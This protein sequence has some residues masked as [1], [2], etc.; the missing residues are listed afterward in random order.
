MV[1]F[2]GR[3]DGNY[4]SS[5][6]ADPVNAE[7]NRINGYFLANGRLS[8][9][10]A[11]KDWQVSVEVRNIFNKYYYLTLVQGNPHTLAPSLAYRGRGQ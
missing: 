11:D 10:T 6:F 3:I 4:Q 7:T 1:I 8:Y 5:V 2:T 9:K